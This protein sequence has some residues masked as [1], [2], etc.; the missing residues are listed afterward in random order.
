[1]TSLAANR[2]M[3]TPQLGAVA[4]AC[5]PGSGTIIT[6]HT[7][8]TGD[9]EHHPAGP[10]RVLGRVPGTGRVPDTLLTFCTDLCSPPAGG[11]HRGNVA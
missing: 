5:G 3:P 10:G 8:V 7:A 4:S 2:L 11:R 9:A 1:M 6:E